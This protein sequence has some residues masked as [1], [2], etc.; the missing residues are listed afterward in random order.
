M[1]QGLRLEEPYIA[2]LIVYVY[3]YYH[4]HPTQP[5]GNNV[6]TDS[7]GLLRGTLM[8]SEVLTI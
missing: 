3:L 5:G 4:S 2:S 1:I 8:A 7:D 6:M